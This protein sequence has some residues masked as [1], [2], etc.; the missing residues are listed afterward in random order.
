MERDYRRSSNLL[1]CKQPRG[2]PHGRT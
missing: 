1:L 2:R